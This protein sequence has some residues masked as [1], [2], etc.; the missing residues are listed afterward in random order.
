MRKFLNAIQDKVSTREHHDQVS[1]A[2]DDGPFPNDSDLFM[3][4]KQRGVNLGSWFVLER[5]IA[6]SPF[7]QAKTPAQSDLDVALGQ[8]A[9]E[10]LER[11]WDTWITEQDFAWLVDR[12]LNTVRLPIGYYHLCGVDPSVL[13]G[14]DFTGLG[15]VFSGAWNRITGAI[16]MAQRYG[17]GVLI[18][19]HAAPG[20]QNRDAHGGT[21]GEPRFFDKKNMS[22]TIQVLTTLLVHLNSFCATHDPPLVNIVGIELLNEPMQN[23]SLEKWY[24]EAIRRLRQ[25]SP[26]P[27]YISDSWATDQY[28]GYIHAHSTEIPFTVLDHHLYRCFT[29]EDIHTP[30]NQHAYQ[31]TDPNAGTPQMFARVA[32]KLQEAGSDLII[33]EW[34]GALNPGSLAGVGD[35]TSARRQYVGAQLALFDKFCAGYFFWTYKKEHPGDKGWSLRDAVESGV[36][37]TRV[38]MEANVVGDDAG[39]EERKDRARDAALQAHSGYWAQYPGNYDHAKF[40]DGFVQGW[41]D[42]WVFFSS[43]SRLPQNSTVPELGFKGP[44]AKRRARDYAKER[45]SNSLWEYEHGFGQ[46]L[47]AAQQDLS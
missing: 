43:V 4:R 47:M 22:H 16:V 24:L 1:I 17:L 28:A 41:E 7:R 36:F 19:L 39:R 29:Q 2:V 45:G 32:Q 20:K 33:G 46:G 40:A 31:L 14:T 12:G 10:V 35:E 18:D 11:H 38:G 25:V 44:W 5:W 3:Y 6:E 15:H 26:M 34:S 30:V 21:S 8:N 13:E 37:P 27:V 9:K 23:P 42:A